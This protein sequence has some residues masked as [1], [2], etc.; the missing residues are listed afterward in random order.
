M[1]LPLGWK[2]FHD[3]ST[4]CNYYHNEKLGLTQWEIPTV[5]LNSNNIDAYSDMDSSSENGSNLNS[6]L[7]DQSHKNEDYLDYNIGGPNINYVNEALGYSKQRPY[8]RPASRII[9]VLCKKADASI[10]FFPCEH[11]CI[12]AE[13]KLKENFCSELE[14]GF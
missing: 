5:E 14:A 4:N 7:P 3:K 13:C 1:N 11:T 6:T 12:C 2:S 10:V 8:Y 9:C